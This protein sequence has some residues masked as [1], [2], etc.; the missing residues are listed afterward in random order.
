MITMVD[1]LVHWDKK[2]K[3]AVF[4]DL[5]TSSREMI[6][7]GTDEELRYATAD[8]FGTPTPWSHSV[9]YYLFLHFFVYDK[10]SPMQRL[11]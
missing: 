9:K 8:E 3:M 6:E 10:L 7:I 5:K 11:F 2:Q 1:L 4:N